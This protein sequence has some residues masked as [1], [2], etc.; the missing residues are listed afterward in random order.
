MARFQAELA[1]THAS[2]YLQLLCKHWSHRFPVSFDATHGTVALDG[3]RCVF[4][5]EAER[6]SLSLEGDAEALPRLSEV[7]SEHLKRFAFRETFELRWRN[8]DDA[9]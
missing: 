8:A 7:V 5:A 3:V 4:D 2:R 9:R 1:T 6:L